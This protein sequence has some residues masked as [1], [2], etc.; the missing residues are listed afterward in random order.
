M[1]SWAATLASAFAILAAVLYSL[2]SLVAH[3]KRRRQ[4]RQGGMVKISEP[5]NPKFE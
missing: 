5:A 2:Y 4:G 1:P 3:F